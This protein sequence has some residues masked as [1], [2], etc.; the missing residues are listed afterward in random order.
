MSDFIMR[1]QITGSMRWSCSCGR[2]VRTLNIKPGNWIVRCTWCRKLYPF[3]I[4]FYHFGKFGSSGTHQERLLPPDR[5]IAADQLGEIESQPLCGSI[6][7]NE[8]MPIAYRGGEW[9]SGQRITLLVDGAELEQQIRDRAA[10]ISSR[11]GR[12]QLAYPI[13]LSRVSRAELDYSRAWFDDPELISADR[14][15]DR[16][17]AELTTQ[18]FL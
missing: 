8:S 3:G 16:S 14:S 12:E 13:E 7:P 15:S 10:Q 4:V 5:F 17:S 9:S 11:A 6:D 1:A 2:V 18:L